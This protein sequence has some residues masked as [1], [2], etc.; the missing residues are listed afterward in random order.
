MVAL[1]K[2]KRDD[3]LVRSQRSLDLTPQSCAPSVCVF[4]CSECRCRTDFCPGLASLPRRLSYVCCAPA[5]WRLQT[6]SPCFFAPIQCN[7]QTWRGVQVSRLHRNSRS[8]FASSSYLSR[9]TTRNEG[10]G[11]GDWRAHSALVKCRTAEL[12][13]LGGRAGGLWVMAI[14]RH[15]RIM[16]CF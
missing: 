13:R 16:R 3:S 1:V 4:V 2:F 11:R 15:T 14:G 5:C 6:F 7:V 12:G 8:P 10:R 9:V